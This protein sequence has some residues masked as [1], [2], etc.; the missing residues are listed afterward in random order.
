MRFRFFISF[1]DYR[2]L[3]E[4]DNESTAESSSSDSQDE[5]KGNDKWDLNDTIRESCG[6]LFINLCN[7]TNMEEFIS[8]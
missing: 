6:K 1:V 7:M 8:F 5:E 3:F 2:S 4:S